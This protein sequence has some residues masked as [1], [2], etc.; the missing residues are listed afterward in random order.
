MCGGKISLNKISA[1]GIA[2]RRPDGLAVLFLPGVPD[3]ERR[4][5]MNSGMNESGPKEPTPAPLSPEA[6]ARRQVGISKTKHLSHE[7]YWERVHDP[8]VCDHC[9]IRHETVQPRTRIQVG[10][11]T[12]R[13]QY[14]FCDWCAK[15]IREKFAALPED[16][17]KRH[18]EATYGSISVAAVTRKNDLH[19]APA[20]IKTQPTSMRRTLLAVGIAVLVSILFAPHQE[21][22]H[23]LGR[24]FYVQLT[25]QE[26]GCETKVYLSTDPRAGIIG[27]DPS[28]RGPFEVTTCKRDSYVPDWCRVWY[29]FPIFWIEP[30][31]PI[32]WGNFAG[33]TAFVAMLAAVIV[34]I[35]RSRT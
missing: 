16:L 3:V 22:W 31:N 6:E 23:W 4:K 13:L 2:N 14:K 15:E 32:L 30:H 1:G 26:R 27:F 9:G 12:G 20:P 17:N 5:I 10:L 21:N 28:G 33:Q 35:R 24:V 18:C 11:E 19:C 8:T 7:E 29:W 25:E 34:N